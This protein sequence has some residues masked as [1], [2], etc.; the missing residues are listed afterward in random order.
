MVKSQL[1]SQ[2][3]PNQSELELPKIEITPPSEP[4][5]N[6]EAN[7]GTKS[8]TTLMLEEC[9]KQ[10]AALYRLKKQELQMAELE[11][12]IALS[13]SKLNYYENIAPSQLNVLKQIATELS[14]IS[15]VALESAL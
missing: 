9:I 12:R 5:T 8:G 6:Q 1:P 10:E 4:M 11:V 13:R 3:I 14:T 15:N 7:S 2:Q